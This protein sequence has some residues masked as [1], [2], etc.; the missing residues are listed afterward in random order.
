MKKGRWRNA[1]AIIA[2][3][4]TVMVLLS[5][6]H[7]AEAF[8]GM[9]S[10]GTVVP[11]EEEFRDLAPGGAPKFAKPDCKETDPGSSARQAGV[12]RVCIGPRR[13]AAESTEKRRESTPL[14]ARVMDDGGEGAPC[15]APE[16]GKY[17]YARAGSCMN[18]MEVEFKEI[19]INGKEI[20]T[21]FLTVTTGEGL[22][23][24]KW[25][26]LI[27]IKWKSTRGVIKGGLD[28]GFSAGC[29]TPCSMAQK[30]PWEGSKPLKEGGELMGIVTFEAAINKGEDH[31]FTTN[32]ELTATEPGTIPIKRVTSWSKPEPIRCDDAVGKYPGCV[33]KVVTP[34]FRLSMSQYG[35]AA[36]TY[37]WAQQSL[38]DH[39]GDKKPLRRMSDETIARSNRRKVCD[40]L[41]DPFERFDDIVPNDSCDEYPFAS[42]YESGASTINSNCADIVPLLE[43]GKWV[44]Y[45]ARKDKPVT[46]E[47]PCV[48]GHVTLDMN[49]KAGGALGNFVQSERILDSD[50]YKVSIYQ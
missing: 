31:S 48:R 15:D 50:R 34:V 23:G 47:E 19:D 21:A 3:A 16:T 45:E 6:P 10:L 1:Y 40:Q 44:I 9:R 26:E 42:T 30:S 43:H 2:F 17:Y 14:A 25:S 36:A 7:Q 4:L 29:G 24:L 20:G 22:D 13:A 11:Q 41:P 46:G 28:I 35:G 39:W 32:Y 37:L 12:Y 49:K 18:D 5:L 27:T 38:W 33:Y 8:E